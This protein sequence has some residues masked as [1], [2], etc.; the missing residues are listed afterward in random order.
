MRATRRAA[1]VRRRGERAARW[2]AERATR[3]R[4]ERA[5]RWRGERAAR[6]RVR[7]TRRRRLV[8][9]TRRRLIGARLLVARGR[10]VRARGT[11]V[12]VVRAALR[13]IRPRGLD[14]RAA[15]RLLERATVRLLVGRSRLPARRSGTVRLLRCEPAVR[16][17][18]H[19]V[20]GMERRADRTDR[21]AHDAAR[22]AEPFGV[23]DERVRVDVVRTEV[24]L[25]LEPPV[26]VVRR[27]AMV[28]N[29]RAAMRMLRAPADVA[30][31][32]TPVDPAWTPDCNPGHQPQ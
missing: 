3:W 29:D 2:R 31:A 17:T 1:R 30:A 28:A 15:V 25:R 8:A 5:T 18:T 22:G 12:R 23:V 4:G 9:A 19:D 21:R 13:R 32:V 7:A 24:A 27:M 6:R 26:R 10:L 16:A 14:E 11:L 20:R